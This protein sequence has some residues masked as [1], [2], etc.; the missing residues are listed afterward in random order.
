MKGMTAEQQTDKNPLGVTT[1]VMSRSCCLLPSMSLLG[2]H[3][4]PDRSP[5]T[6]QCVMAAMQYP[7]NCM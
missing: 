5:A 4:L 2:H 1:C 3:S 6:V 7:P